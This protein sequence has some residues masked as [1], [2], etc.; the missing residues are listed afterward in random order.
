MITTD[1]SNPDLKK[2]KENGQNEAYI[3][4]SEEERAKGFVRP[5]RDTYVHVGKVPLYKGIHQML[6]ETDEHYP[7]YVAVM[8]VM[9]KEDGSFLG[10]SYVTQEE[11]DAWQNNKMIGGCGTSTTMNSREIVE[12]YARNPSFY[13]ATF[14]CGC[15]KH[16]PVGE[17][18]WKGT[19]E[20][21]G[22]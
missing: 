18:V 14:C 21:V 17:F 10:G 1:R 6:E 7:K 20:R 16:L 3:V 19:N 11:L 9:E 22:S 13:G 8:T 15:G 5:L 4:L 12:T 2:V